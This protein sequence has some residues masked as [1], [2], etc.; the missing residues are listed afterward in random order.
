MLDAKAINSSVDLESSS[1][2]PSHSTPYASS[3]PCSNPGRALVIEVDG[4]TYARIPVRTHVVTDQDDILD[5]AQKYAGPLVQSGDVVVVSEKVVA[6]TQGRAVPIEQIRVGALAKLLWPRVRQVRYGIGLRSPY[7]MQCAIDECGGGRIL[8]AAVVG[9]AG[10]LLGRKGD[11]Y[12]VAG[13]QAAMID[14]AGTAGIDA[15]KGSV[16]KGPQDP[17]GVARRLS[18]RLQCGAAVVDVNDVGG[19]WAVGASPGLNRRLVEQAMRDNP[20]GQSAEQTP[21][22]IIRRLDD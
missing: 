8:L 4:D 20:L 12:R 18:E 16:I 5:V 14:A 10:K 3:E 1:Q 2:Q 9:A 21:I 15:F 6:I 19:S 22:G 13:I 11:F 17:D 7:S